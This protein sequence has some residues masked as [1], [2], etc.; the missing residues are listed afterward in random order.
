[1]ERILSPDDLAWIEELESR[2]AVELANQGIS[3]THCQYPS[4]NAAR[5]A[6][7]AEAVHYGMGLMAPALPDNFDAAVAHVEANNAKARR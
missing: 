1:M 6:M 3:S 4:A 7:I 5:R 2:F